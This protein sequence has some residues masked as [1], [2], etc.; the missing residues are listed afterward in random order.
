YYLTMYNE[1]YKQPAMPEGSADGILRGMYRLS[2]TDGKT[3]RSSARPQLLGSGPIL[4]E[5]LKAQGILADR[6]GIDSDV[7]SVTSY[8][9]LRRDAETVDGWNLLHTD[10]KPRMSYVQQCLGNSSGPIVA[11]TD[12]V[13]LV[14][15]QISRWLPSPL[16]PLGTDGF[17]RSDTRRALRR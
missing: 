15:E 7:W 8:N 12:Y 17:G 2:S 1:T 16:V 5:V 6:Y 14:P 9:E 3:A 10:E 13:R 4:R 11:A